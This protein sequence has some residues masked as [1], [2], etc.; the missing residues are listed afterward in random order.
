MLATVVGDALATSTSIGV[1][2]SLKVNGVVSCVILAIGA[3]SFAVFLGKGVVPVITLV[4]A[5]V[6][7]AVGVVTIVITTGEVVVVI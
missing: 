4:E 1:V 5:A 6:G 2:G 7:F 3:V